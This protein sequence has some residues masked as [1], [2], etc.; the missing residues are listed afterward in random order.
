MLGGKEITGK[1]RDHARE[2][3]QMAG[4]PDQ[5]GRSTRRKA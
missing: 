3:L 4:N 1:A 2:M 5:K